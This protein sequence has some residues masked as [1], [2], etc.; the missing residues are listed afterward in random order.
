MTE[1]LID[2]QQQILRSV[3]GMRKE[4]KTSL[5]QLDSR[6]EAIEQDKLMHR[7]RMQAVEQHV[8]VFVEH[9]ASIQKRLDDIAVRMERLEQL[10]V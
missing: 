7:Q 3:N 4:V 9:S 10:R 1:E 5:G 2:I 6:L 8:A